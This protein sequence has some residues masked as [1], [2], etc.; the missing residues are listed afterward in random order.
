MGGYGGAVPNPFPQLPG[1]TKFSSM[2]ITRADAIQLGNYFGRPAFRFYVDAN[3]RHSNG[4]RAEFT[5]GSDYQFKAGDTFEYRFSVYFAPDYKNT[6]WEQW[7]LFAQFHGPGFPAWGLHTAGGYL[8]MQPPSVAANT[9][10][11]PMPA[12]GVW[13]D[14]RWTIRWSKDGTGSATLAI[15]GA[16]V[17][18]HRGAT[19][20]A[21]VD[22]YYPKF[23]AY[24]ANNAYTQVAYQTP[25]TITRK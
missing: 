17:F 5:G 12:R 1:T 19:M 24:L 13:H 9:Y 18:S 4:L 22:H 15:D 23:G 25:W 14:L 3:S 2:Q 7:N 16:T 21:S 6:T 8:H 10:R 11:V 20:H